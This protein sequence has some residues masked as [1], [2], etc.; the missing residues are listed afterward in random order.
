MIS[1][2]N[3][4]SRICCVSV[5]AL[6]T[7]CKP[8]DTAWFRGKDLGSGYCIS[9]QGKLSVGVLDANNFLV[10]ER[11]VLDFT[12][13][14]RF[15]IAAQRPWT[16]VPNRNQM[17]YSASRAA[18]ESS[19]FIQYWII[20]KTM[21]GKWDAARKMFTNLFGPYTRAEYLEARRTLGVPDSL[22]VRTEN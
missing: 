2:L 8:F 17:N 1:S 11:G 9:D 13:D 5:L 7:G 4:L 18:F 21:K 16:V 12:F 3:R 19:N 20:D 15:I 14:D 22:L 10:I 6:V